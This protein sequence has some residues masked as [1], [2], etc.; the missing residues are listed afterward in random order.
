[1]QVFCSN[2]ENHLDS[3]RQVTAEMGL[4][5]DYPWFNS[6]WQHYSPSRR[7]D[8][9]LAEISDAPEH[10][11]PT[12]RA[13]KITDEDHVVGLFKVL[14]ATCLLSQPWSPQTDLSNLWQLLSNTA[15]AL[16][17]SSGEA[18][19]HSHLLLQ[20]F[21][22]LDLGLQISEPVLHPWRHP[23]S[24]A[25]HTKSGRELSVLSHILSKSKTLNFVHSKNNANLPQI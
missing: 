11:S 3:W 7:L 21:S 1:M 10:T 23:S 14:S 9:H 6:Y 17:L 5:N 16:S 15:T 4:A 19:P 25:T 24:L 22:D 8:S 18:A 20:A 2:S 12:S 13:V